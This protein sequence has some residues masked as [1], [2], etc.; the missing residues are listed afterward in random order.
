[1][2][3]KICSWCEE[4]TK[5]LLEYIDIE[6]NK[7]LLCENCRGNI[8]FCG[9]CGRVT[10]MYSEDFILEET[11]TITCIHCY[12]KRF[13][14]KRVWHQTDPWRGHFS[15]E[16]ID[17]RHAIA[18]ECSLVPHEE[19]ESM[20]NIVKEFLDLAGF[21]SKVLTGKTSNIFSRNLIIIA[22]KDK[23]LTKKDRR[24]LADLNNAFV[25]HYTR[26]F[27]I[28]SGRLYPID[29]MAFKEELRKI[30]KKR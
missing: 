15:F 2:A 1:L 23:A 20:I 13:G 27:S 7:L 11:E 26:G 18:V 22:W 25:M 16:P 12:A 5:D 8:I 9:E 29:L 21:K 6:G 10:D 3:Q 19:N 14:V 28:L 30:L 17:N 24:L 4:K